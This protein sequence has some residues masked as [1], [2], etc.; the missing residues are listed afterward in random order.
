MIADQPQP[1]PIEIGL[2]AAIVAVAEQQPLIL[3]VSPGGDEPDNLPFGP[4]NPLAHRT[5]EAGLRAWVAEQTA[6]KLGHVEQLYTF[7]DRGRHT[8]PGDTG[9]HLVSVG[10]LAL[11][12]ISDDSPEELALARAHWRHWYAFFP[13]EDWREGRPAVLD[14]AILPA[15]TRWSRTEPS[16]DPAEW[17]PLGGASAC[18]WLSATTGRAGTRSGRSTA[19]SYSTKPAWWP[20]P[21]AT[22]AGSSIAPSPASREPPCAS[23]T[24]ASWPPPFPGCAPS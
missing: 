17:R 15:L 7:G 19:M 22:G 8:S 23:I 3:V 18:C 20:R 13:W 4:F 16:S 1:P 14:E 24:A 5:F 12:R 11:T 21:N 9:P 10:Y 2:H 6:L